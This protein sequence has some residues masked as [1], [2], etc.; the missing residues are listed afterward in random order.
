M[1]R[2]LENQLRVIEELLQRLQ[3]LLIVRDP[4]SGPAADAYDG[5]R[6][7]VVASAAERTAHLA[8]LARLDA[9]VQRDGASVEAISMLMRDL[10]AEAGIERTSEWIDGSF[11]V[12]DG[13]GDRFEVIEPAY[14]EP[15]TGRLV[16]RG[17]ARRVDT[18]ADLIQGV[19]AG[20]VAAATVANNAG[21]PELPKADRE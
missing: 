18:S 16:R 10:L 6:R 2:E 5:L 17:K 3:M 12:L 15:S 19:A 8:H 14:A 20:D 1:R 9:E 4:A 7:A 11:D 13:T 21:T